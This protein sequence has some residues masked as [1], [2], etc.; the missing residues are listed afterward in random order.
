MTEKEAIKKF[1]ECANND[2]LTGCLEVLQE[3]SV[4]T[5]NEQDN[6]GYNMLISAAVAGNPCAVEALIKSGKCDLTLEMVC[7]KSSR[8]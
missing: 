7:L 2:D 5:I 6:D 8:F 3:I 1:Y 4:H